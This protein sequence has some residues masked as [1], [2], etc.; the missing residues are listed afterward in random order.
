[1]LEVRLGAGK[2]HIAL[3]AATG[4]GAPTIGVVGAGR[5]RNG[6]GIFL[7]RY[8][9]R[10]GLRVGAIAGRMPQRAA[11]QAIALGDALGHPVDACRDVDA[12]CRSG[13]AAL[14]VAT[15]TAHHRAA[16]ESALAARL[17]VL[18]EKPLFDAHEQAAGGAIIDGFAAAGVPCV[19]HCQWPFVLPPLLRLLGRAPAPARQVEL[20]L[21]AARA[22]REMVSSML[23]H[24]LSVVQALAALDADTM[25]A[26]AV[27]DPPWLDGRPTRV[28]VS[29]RAA[30]GE[31]D[32]ALHLTLGAAPPRPAWIA[33]DGARLD[34]R[35]DVAAG[36]AL[37]FEGA[38]GRIAVDD[39]SQ[40]LVD[41]FAA[42][43]RNPQ[44][45]QVHA[46]LA[47]LRARQRVYREVLAMLWP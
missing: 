12:L 25:V 21:V 27:L 45:V 44:P 10:A 16:L 17:P 7:A 26:D 19:E 6:L 35:V 20:G 42:L 29:L 41:D 22:G 36:Y 38:A 37:S 47:A 23:P 40:A 24:L 8:A 33:I 5:T 18:C 43:V 2:R 28:R 30:W 3:A 32:A 1:V 14:I 46:Q 11:A 15:P 13:I 31:V 39:P 9:E 4:V 34:R